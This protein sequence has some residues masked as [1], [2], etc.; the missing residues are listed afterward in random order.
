M[1]DKQ[2][3]KANGLFPGTECD[4]L[5]GSR[6]PFCSSR[7]QLRMLLSAVCFSSSLSGAASVV[8]PVCLH[9][10]RENKIEGGILSSQHM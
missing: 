4:G 9:H 7:Q 1:L 6:V 10:Q 8:K 5:L 3:W 2:A